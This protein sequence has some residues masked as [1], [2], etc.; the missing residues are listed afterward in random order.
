[1][2]GFFVGS[3][4]ITTWCRR[5][6]R[7]LPSFFRMVNAVGGSHPSTVCRSNLSRT[8]DT[9]LP[10]RCCREYR[11]ALPSRG[12]R[13]RCASTHARLRVV[14]LLNLLDVLE[15]GPD[16]VSNWMTT[17]RNIKSLATSSR[18]NRETASLFPKS[19]YDVEQERRADAEEKDPVSRLGGAH[20]SPLPC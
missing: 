9:R 7:P 11:T 4:S 19:D 15:I 12:S 5:H 3:S 20:H 10:S 6:R 13:S 8:Q 16:S 1:M 14:P 2:S 17:P 18:S